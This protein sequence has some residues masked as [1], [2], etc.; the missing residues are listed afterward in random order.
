M[1]LCRPFFGERGTNE[2]HRARALCYAMS[3]F[4]VFSSIQSPGTYRNGHYGLEWNGY[5]E[6]PI[7]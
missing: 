6:S 7:L 5:F 2:K 1:E 3:P 4:Q